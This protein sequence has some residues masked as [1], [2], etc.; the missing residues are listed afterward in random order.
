MPIG[1]E[2]SSARLALRNWLG[3]PLKVVRRQRDVRVAGGDQRA[4]QSDRV[5]KVRRPDRRLVCAPCP[6]LHAQAG[7]L[8]GSRGR[9]KAGRDARLSEKASRRD[10]LL[11]DQRA[12]VGKSAA[13]LREQSLIFGVD[14]GAGARRS[15]SPPSTQQHALRRA[16]KSA[17]ESRPRA[18]Q[19]RRTPARPAPPGSDSDSPRTSAASGSA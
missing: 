5:P 19:P 3:Q 12:A 1:P 2:P 14:R 17:S 9:A 11:G 7:A 13:Q 10:A 15:R 16:R 4:A 18:K 8:R 6:R